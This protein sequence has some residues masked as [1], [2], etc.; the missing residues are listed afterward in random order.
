[1][2]RLDPELR[3]EDK[4]DQDK[5]TLM[6]IVIYIAWMVIGYAQVFVCCTTPLYNN[7]E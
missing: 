3:E 5:I 2:I 4:D 1:M 7:N 6:F